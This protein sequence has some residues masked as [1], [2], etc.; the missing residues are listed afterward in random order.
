[1]VLI[2]VWYIHTVRKHEKKPDGSYLRV[3]HTLSGD[4]SIAFICSF[5]LFYEAT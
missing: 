5:L 3:F 2:T 4:I 1:M